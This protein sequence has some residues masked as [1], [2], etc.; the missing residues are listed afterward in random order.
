ML[1]RKSLLE[2]LVGIGFWRR[3]QVQTCTLHLQFCCRIQTLS[4]IFSASAAV[5][6]S[7]HTSYWA[8]AGDPAT[9]STSKL[10]CHGGL[11]L[12]APRDPFPLGLLRLLTVNDGKHFLK[13]IRQYNMRFMLASIKAN[14]NLTNAAGA[15]EQSLGNNGT[16]HHRYC[17]LEPAQTQDGS[18]LRP[19]QR[20]RADIHHGQQRMPFP[21]LIV[22]PSRD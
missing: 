21:L 7:H 5:R 18:V 15:G 4:S 12:F 9:N 16:C 22:C 3:I 20:D 2:Q 11:L 8:A 14:V 19:R 17:P 1:V 10:C 13:H 6:K